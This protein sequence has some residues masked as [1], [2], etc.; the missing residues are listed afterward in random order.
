VIAPCFGIVDARA[1][2]GPP[3]LPQLA[4]KVAVA[5]SSRIVTAGR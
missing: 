5:I 2:L 4:S 3:P 1:E